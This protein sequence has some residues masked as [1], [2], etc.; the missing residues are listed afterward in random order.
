MVYHYAAAWPEKR[1]EL[2]LSR[3]LLMNNMEVRVHEEISE[4]KEKFYGL[5]LRQWIS[6]IITVI[7]DVPFYILL[8][9]YIQDDILQILV[10]IISGPVL[11]IG[12]V[13][14]QQLP[15]EKFLKYFFRNY[16]NLYKPLEYKSDQEVQK[17]KEYYQSLSF[18]QKRKYRKNKKKMENIK[19]TIDAEKISHESID[20]NNELTRAERKV[21]KKQVKI[22]KKEQARIQKIEKKRQKEEA[23]RQKIINKMRAKE[24]KRNRRYRKHIDEQETIS[25]K[26]TESYKDD[27]KEDIVSEMVTDETD[28]L[29]EIDN[30]FEDNNT[31]N[32]TN[33]N[34]TESDDLF[35][36]RTDDIHTVVNDTVNDV[37]EDDIAKQ[38]IIDEA[39]TEETDRSL[40]NA[41]EDISITDD[42]SVSESDIK[43]DK[44]NNTDIDKKDDENK[45][46]KKTEIDYDSLSKEELIAIM[47]AIVSKEGD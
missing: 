30:R 38:N 41:F 1:L 27:I 12:F 10:I 45:S 39:L 15:M 43:S 35:S 25:D 42:Q 9:N 28:K 11:L 22:E 31:R 24:E 34:D 6:V 5:T 8:S 13:R 18:F 46:S 26:V 4:Y 19:K 33:G 17:E 47:K 3:G 37:N 7:V 14:F 32:K 16:F 23:K 44:K 2:L 20:G 40:S 36:R 21:L 29:E